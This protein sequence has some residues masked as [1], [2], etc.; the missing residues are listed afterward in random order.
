MLFGALFLAMGG[1]TLVGSRRRQRTWLPRTGRVVNSRLDGDGQI[2]VQ[3]AFQHE[4]RPITFWNRFTTGSVIDPVGRDVDILVNPADP[5][6]AVVARGAG[7][8][9]TVGWAFVAFGVIAVVVG[10]ILTVA[11]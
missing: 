3:V 11:G 1:S 8:P 5:A 9:S 4:G 6:D 10:I 2:R 7:R